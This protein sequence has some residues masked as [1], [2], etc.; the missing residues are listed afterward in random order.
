MFRCTLIIACL[1]AVPAQ[2]YL[3]GNDLVVEPEGPASFSVP[4]RGASGAPAFWCAAGEYARVAL[5]AA[6]GARIYRLSEPPRRS[7]EGIR[8]SMNPEGA[9]SRTG[10]GV[11][12]RDDGSLSV[13]HAEILC[14][15]YR[16]VDPD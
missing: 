8:F 14:D 7:G 3:A 10:L 15:A 9:A 12:G 2:A 11:V 4:F 13:F 6:P 16:R 5:G 1:A